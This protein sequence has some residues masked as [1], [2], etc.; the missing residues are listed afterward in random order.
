MHLGFRVCVLDVMWAALMIS[1]GGYQASRP[2]LKSQAGKE[3]PTLYCWVYIGS[4]FL[5]QSPYTTTMFLSLSSLASLAGWYNCIMAAYVLDAC[6]AS[7]CTLV[8][9]VEMW[10]L[11]LLRSGT[12]GAEKAVDKVN[13]QTSAHHE[14]DL[15]KLTFSNNFAF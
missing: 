2:S 15:V 11:Q 14:D 5:P 4:S 7:S 9:I 13:A 12:F 1:K 8:H 6:F 3:G 10:Y